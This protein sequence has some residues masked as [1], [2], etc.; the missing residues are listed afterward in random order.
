MNASWLR[1]H[2]DGL[3]LTVKVVPRASRTAVAGCEEGWLRLRL[4]A[5]PVDGKANAALVAW[6]VK[7]LGVPRGAVA[8][9]SG[10]SAR[11]KRIHVRGITSAQAVARLGLAE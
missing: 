2:D 9:V 1:P 10:H 8:L 3:L 7:S 11:L 6:L 4:Q 5:P